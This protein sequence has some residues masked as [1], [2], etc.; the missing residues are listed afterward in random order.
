[1]KQLFWSI[2]MMISFITPA[3]SQN[4]DVGNKMMKQKIS[5]NLDNKY[6]AFKSVAFQIWD[7]AEVG[8]KE[9][10]SSDLLQKTLKD[11]GFN[12]ESGVAGMPTA[13]VAT[14]GTG[15]PVIGILGEF[16]AL[17][18][19]S[20]DASPVKSPRADKIAGH[21]C[22]HHLFGA[23]SAAAAIEVKDMMDKGLVKG[24]IKFYG[25]PAEEGGSGKVYM[26]R[27][28]LFK[29]VDVVLHWHPGDGNSANPSSSLA[30]ISAKFRFYGKSAHAAGAPFR[31]R[32]ALDG[33]ESMDYM[34]NM[35][36]EHVT[37]E[38]RMH[39][40]ITDGGKAPN[41]V[42]DFAEVYYY[43]RHPDREEVRS[44]FERLKKAAEGAA[45]GTETRME[46]EII[47]GVYNLLPLESLAKVMHANMKIVGGVKYTES[48]IEFAK[49]IQMSYGTEALPAIASSEEVEPYKVE[50]RSGGSTDVGDIS[51]TVPTVGCRT[52]TWVPGTPAHSWQAVSCG[53]NDLSARGMMVAAKTIAMT[54]YD[55]YTT[56]ALLIEA[57]TEFIKARGANFKY[58]SLLGDRPPALDYRD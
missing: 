23:G 24:T 26:V 58:A 41:V 51:W 36:R 40:V 53:I 49:K 11:A 43:V 6:D 20:Q 44:L 28:G 30:N 5:D 10:K 4:S 38:T 33:V 29:D 56:P 14:Y 42:P 52:A 37:P 12:V 25:T 15:S 3:T 48:E 34:A 50:N 31:G 32:S 1:M 8:F 35:M 54:A 39:Y 19:L 17:P 46:Y 21:A 9:E 2:L 55:L 57:K 45:L 47:G 13:F 18:G 22:G 7:F 16:D 27:E